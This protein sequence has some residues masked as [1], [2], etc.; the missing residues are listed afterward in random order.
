MPEYGFSLPR[1]SRIL[2]YFYTM[3]TLILPHILILF[4]NLVTDD[5]NLIITQAATGR[6]L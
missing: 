6:V 4:F 3:F 1:T 2:A 5:K